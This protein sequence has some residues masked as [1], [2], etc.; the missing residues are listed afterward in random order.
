MRYVIAQTESLPVSKNR[1]IP[2][3]ALERFP[4]PMQILLIRRTRKFRT[5]VR[6]FTELYAFTEH[7]L[8]QFNVKYR[9]LETH[10]KQSEISFRLQCFIETV[11]AGYLNH[12]NSVTVLNNFPIK[13]TSRIS[14]EMLKITFKLRW[15]S[16][17]YEV[18]EC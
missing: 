11:A 8:K 4:Q 7:A 16:L 2:L 1:Q 10:F 15:M 14:F 17:Q 13:I 9:Y 18:K 12:S 6:A 3:R 5:L